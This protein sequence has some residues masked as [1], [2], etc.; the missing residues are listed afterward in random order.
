[1]VIGTVEACNI[2]F[3]KQSLT[4]AAYEGA[5]IAI[6]SGST[7]ADVETQCQQILTERKVGSGTIT[8]NP[9]IVSDVPRG[10]YITVTVSAPSDANAILKGWFY[11]NHTLQGR[12]TMMKEF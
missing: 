6:G 7:T 10:A 3:L 4:T 1:L 12:A 5:R 11:T 9:P 8:V 2:I